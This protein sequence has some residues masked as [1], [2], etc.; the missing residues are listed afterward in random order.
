MRGHENK[1]SFVLLLM[2]KTQDFRLCADVGQAFLAGVGESSLPSLERM[3]WTVLQGRP[4]VMY[5][6]GQHFWSSFVSIKLE[7]KK[8]IKIKIKK[9]KKKKEYLSKSG[10]HLNAD[11][12]P[13]DSHEPGPWTSHLAIFIYRCFLA[14]GHGVHKPEKQDAN[15]GSVT[16][17]PPIISP[18]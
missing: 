15:L 2:L 10:S 8:K 14:K 18:D 12:F 16:P 17:G 3:A 11:F 7:L 4:T 1:I 6:R 9:L 13:L 5:S